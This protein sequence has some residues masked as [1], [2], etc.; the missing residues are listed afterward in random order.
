MATVYYYR[1]TDSFPSYL[2]SSSQGV[3]GIYT[4]RSS[5]LG[6]CLW[7]YTGAFFSDTHFPET[8]AVAHGYHWYRD[9]VTKVSREGQ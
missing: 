1:I 4:R 6:V 8:L 7:W 5:F 2:Y 3:D 9:V